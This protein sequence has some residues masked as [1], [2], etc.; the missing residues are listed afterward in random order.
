[1]TLKE[2]IAICF[3]KGK[4]KEL[5]FISSFDSDDVEIILPTDEQDR[6]EH[7]DVSISGIKYDVKSMKNIDRPRHKSADELTWEKNLLD[8]LDDETKSAIIKVPNQNIHWLEIKNV[9]GET[10]SCYGNADEFAFELEDY[11]IIVE[12]NKI[13]DFIKENVKRDEKGRPLKSSQK[14]FY[15]LYNRNKRGDITM[16]VSSYDLCYISKKMIK[17]NKK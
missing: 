10:G 11:W 3:D 5:E 7:W 9:K 14:K 17:K 2:A 1:M 15:Y 4:K 8:K 6:E 12:K 13:Q 16:L